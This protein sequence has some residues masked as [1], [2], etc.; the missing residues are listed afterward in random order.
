MVRD[1]RAIQVVESMSK[2]QRSFVARN[3]GPAATAITSISISTG[4]VLY[5]ASVYLTG[6]FLSQGDVEFVYHSG[7]RLRMFNPIFGFTVEQLAVHVI[8]LLFA[9]PGLLLLSWGGARLIKSASE[10][11][12][13]LLTRTMWVCVL[14]AT[15]FVAWLTFGFFRGNAIVDDELTYNMQA[16]LLSEGRLGEKGLPPIEREPFTIESKVGMTGKYLPGE[17][18]LQI[19]GILVG[20]PAAVHVLLFFL[21]LVLLFMT[22]DRLADR[23]L[24]C[25]SVI[26]LAIS[27]MSLFTSA[28]GQSQIT[29]LFSICLAGYGYALVAGPRALRGSILAAAAVGAGL[30]VRPQSAAPMGGAIMVMIVVSLLRRRRYGS[31]VAA[32]L[33]LLI[34]VGGILFYNSVVTGDALVL[35]WC[36]YR[37]LEPYGFVEM[38]KGWR[39]T[40]GMGLANLLSSIIRLN[41]WWLGWPCGFLLIVLWFRW[42]RPSGGAL[43][44]WAIGAAAIVAFQFGYYSPGVADTGPIYYFELLIPLSILG[45]NAIRAGF[46]QS[47]RFITALLLVHLFLGATWF[48]YYQYGRI[49][50]LLDAIHQD[51]ERVLAEIP[52]PA[53]LFYEDHCSESA[54]AGWLLSGFGRRCRVGRCDVITYPRPPEKELPMYRQRYPGRECWYYR[55]RPESGTPEILRCEDAGHLLKRPVR[56][57]APCISRRSTASKMGL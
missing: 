8:G 34:S 7:F 13:R 53:L 26:L 21:T 49:G 17:P 40:P 14:A 38:G 48:F 50:R 4:L 1:N 47:P 32:S 22:V 3:T 57:D 10:P 9:A 19:P 24:A 28:T 45:A 11:S 43:R 2:S 54:R 33:I 6:G 51:Q 15:G 41:E 5:C 44:I 46:L 30:W 31:V 12:V 52:K 20:Y 39:H 25:W 56:L 35:P 16:Q 27:P 18:L 23:R 37:P 55:L 42:G 29:S 36:L